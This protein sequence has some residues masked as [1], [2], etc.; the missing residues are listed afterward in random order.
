VAN[1]VRHHHERWDGKGYP[2]GLAGTG[3]DPLARIAAIAVTFDAMTSDRPY[4]KGLSFATARAE[5]AKNSGSQFDPDMALLL[6]RI[7]DAELIQSAQELH[8]WC[9]GDRTASTRNFLGFLDID[10]PKVK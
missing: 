5:I 7:T 4:R 3:I 1:I 10:R 2:D 6:T 9:S 8:V